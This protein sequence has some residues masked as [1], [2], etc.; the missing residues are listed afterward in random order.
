MY[1]CKSNIRA[2]LLLSHEQTQQLK[3]NQPMTSRPK[4]DYEDFVRGFRAACAQRGIDPLEGATSF[5]VVHYCAERQLAA[6]LAL[7]PKR[8]WLRHHY[9]QA[10]LPH[11]SE[12]EEET[13]WNLFIEGYTLELNRVVR[14]MRLKR[15]NLPL[16]ELHQLQAERRKSE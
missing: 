14:A 9:W 10:S 13:F 5:Q 15:M 2:I 7:K 12:V 6:R 1:L 11:H 16:R 4:F 3:M 8:W